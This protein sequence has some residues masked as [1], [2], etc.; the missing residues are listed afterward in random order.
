MTHDQAEM[1]AIQALGWLAGDDAL[2]PCFLGA[3][4]AD[5]ADL[6]DRAADPSFLAEVLAFVTA[7]DARIIAFCDSTGLGYDQPLRARY[8]L[9]GQA[10]VSWT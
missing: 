5:A 4:G 7:D 3:T 2:L 1:I 6:R 9:P 10:E 8:A